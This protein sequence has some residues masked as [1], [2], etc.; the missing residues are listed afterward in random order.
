MPRTSELPSDLDPDELKEMICDLGR[1]KGLPPGIHP[2][3]IGPDPEDH[4]YWGCGQQDRHRQSCMWRR[5]LIAELMRR[6][7][8]VAEWRAAQAMDGAVRALCE[9]KGLTFRPWEC[10]PWQVRVD[11]EVPEQ[12]GSDRLWDERLAQRLRR[13]LECEIRAEDARKG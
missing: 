7:E 8:W 10:P 12:R 3:L 4:N 2:H 11:D 5:K 13:E 1:E 6:P 9:R